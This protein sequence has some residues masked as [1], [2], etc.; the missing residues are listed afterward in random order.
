MM[1]A[2]GK[3]GFRARQ[4][5]AFLRPEAPD[6]GGGDPKIRYYHSYWQLGA[7]EALNTA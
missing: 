3:K 5:A 2:L 6:D 4:H 1:F 7:D